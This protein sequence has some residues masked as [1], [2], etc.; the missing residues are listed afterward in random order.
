MYVQAKKK[1]VFYIILTFSYSI[2]H[3]R[4]RAGALIDQRWAV[5]IASPPRV[6]L[7]TDRSPPMTPHHSQRPRFIHHHPDPFV[8]LFTPCVVFDRPKNHFTDYITTN[9]TLAELGSIQMNRNDYPLVSL[10]E[11]EVNGFVVDKRIRSRIRRIYQSW[12][13]LEFIFSRH[14]LA[15]DRKRVTSDSSS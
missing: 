1:N 2:I 7:G 5:Y 3:Q 11:R 15:Q 14:A 6:Q 10:R 8:F 13:L 4:S 9:L 12:W